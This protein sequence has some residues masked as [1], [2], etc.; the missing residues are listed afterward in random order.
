MCKLDAKVKAEVEGTLCCFDAPAKVETHEIG[1]VD[2]PLSGLPV[3][4]LFCT[5]P[6]LPGC[7]Y[8]IIQLAKYT[9][10]RC[11]NPYM[12]VPA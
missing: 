9:K 3:L 10:C 1:F 4:L 11:D 7:L 6:C 8:V 5:S 12:R 2:A